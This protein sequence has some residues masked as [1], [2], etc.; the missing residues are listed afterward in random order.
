LAGHLP[1]TLYACNMCS[2]FLGNKTHLL[3]LIDY[4]LLLY[5][6]IYFSIVSIVMFCLRSVNVKLYLYDENDLATWHRVIGANLKLL[7]TEAHMETSSSKFPFKT[8]LI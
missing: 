8:L 4:L 7:I 6:T 2:Y 5:V 3:I 1:N